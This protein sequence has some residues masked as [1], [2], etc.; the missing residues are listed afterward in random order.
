M[1]DEQ[2]WGGREETATGRGQRGGGSSEK[3]AGRKQ[4]GESSNEEAARVGSSTA[5]ECNGEK[6]TGMH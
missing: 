1:V 5:R 2:Q 3:A 4:R 6:A